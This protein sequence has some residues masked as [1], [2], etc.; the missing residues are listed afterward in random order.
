MASLSPNRRGCVLSAQTRLPAAGRQGS[1]DLKP[2]LKPVPHSQVYRGG[3]RRDGAWQ[4]VL[5]VHL[6]F[7]AWCVFLVSD[8]LFFKYSPSTDVKISLYTQHTKS[9]QRKSG[10]A[11][12]CMIRKID[13]QVK[14]LQGRLGGSVG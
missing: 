5:R 9:W 1:T 14:M 7:M 12:G 6:K 10:P 13:K 8:E 4:A 3:G 11:E 2:R